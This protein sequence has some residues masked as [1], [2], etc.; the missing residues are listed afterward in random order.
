MFHTGPN[1]IGYA[2]VETFTVFVSLGAVLM[3]W[4]A[5]EIAH[6]VG[7][8]RAMRCPANARCLHVLPWY[9]VP[10]PKWIDVP[11]TVLLT[12][13]LVGHASLL[14]MHAAAL[15]QTGYAHMLRNKR[16]YL[17]IAVSGALAG[18]VVA[19]P[20][21]PPAPPPPVAQHPAYLHGLSDLRA[22]RW[23][24]EHR[25]GDW[26][27]SAD[28]VEAVRRID[29]AINE[30]KH[31]AIDDGKNPS[32]HPALDERPNHRGRIREAIEY[33]RKARSDISSGE[34]NA[35]ANGLRDRA[36]GHIDGAIGAARRVF[37]D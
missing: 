13:A 36:I 7:Q 17:A 19:P 16:L 2:V 37:H 33:L 4:L 18:C 31:A 12:D 30:I 20:P 5:Y 34:D 22:A 28:E 10:E 11:V 27:Q 23:L 8:R 24:I 35:F 6:S 26:Q 14:T 21:P 1:A 25:P 3:G 32:F 15:C 29:A 9:W